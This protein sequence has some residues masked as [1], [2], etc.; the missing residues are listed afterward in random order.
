MLIIGISG[1]VLTEQ[2][3]A[4][5]QHPAVAG[6]IL[7]SRN[8]ADIDQLQALCRSIRAATARY[9][10]ICVDQ[11]GGR[12]QRFRN[13]FSALPCLER[14]G[15]LSAEDLPLGLA[16]AEQH[17]YLMASE[18]IASGLDLSFAPVADLGRGNR[19]PRVFG[20]AGNRRRVHHGVCQRHARR[21]HGGD[22]ET[23]SR[24]RLRARRHPFR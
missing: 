11:E 6:V 10:L 2:E 19:Q 9:M 1:H 7:F 18:I 21:R 22:L 13:G 14:I 5:L 12:V 20:P 4:F 3:Q 24:T 17:A 16:L 23:F 15:A 8:Y